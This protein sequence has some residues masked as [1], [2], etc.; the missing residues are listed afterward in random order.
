MI[1]G[2]KCVN[3]T[4]YHSHIFRRI[5]ESNILDLTQNLKGSDT[6]WEVWYSSILT[7]SHGQPL[8]AI[9]SSSHISSY[10]Q[11]VYN[12]IVLKASPPLRQTLSL[13]LT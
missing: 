6:M 5:K 3:Y 8:L 12:C 7:Y 2:G 13:V 9:F 4:V 10:T 1:F 11:E